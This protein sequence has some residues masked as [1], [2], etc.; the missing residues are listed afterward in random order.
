MA[1]K[2]ATFASIAVWAAVPAIGTKSAPDEPLR[3]P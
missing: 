2:A 1:L 3:P